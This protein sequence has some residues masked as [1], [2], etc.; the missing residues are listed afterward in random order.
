MGEEQG[1]QRCDTCGRFL[2]FA[3]LC[4]SRFNYTPLNEFGPE[5]SSFTGPCC[6]YRETPT[7]PRYP[8]HPTGQD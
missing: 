7:P 3:D 8:Q 2:A 6:R 5:E 1:A 4:F